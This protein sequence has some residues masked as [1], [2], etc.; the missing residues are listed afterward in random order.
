MVAATGMPADHFCLACYS[1]DYPLPP[2]ANIGKFCFEN[3][4]LFQ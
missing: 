3:A 2:P 1:G 4:E